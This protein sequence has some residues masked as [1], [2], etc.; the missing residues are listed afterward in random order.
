M[1]KLPWTRRFAFRKSAVRR[2]L[3]TRAAGLAICS[4]VDA[5]LPFVFASMLLCCFCHAAVL[6]AIAQSN[7]NGRPLE[8]AKTYAGFDSNLYPGDGQLRQLRRSFDLSDDA[9]KSAGMHRR[10]KM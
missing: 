10:P 5:I 2:S 4:P 9:T 3:S 1:L 7:G 6:P 8:P